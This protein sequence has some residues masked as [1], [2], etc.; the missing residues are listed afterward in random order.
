MGHEQGARNGANSISAGGSSAM[1]TD[2]ANH[3]S[4]DSGNAD[5]QLAALEQTLMGIRASGTTGLDGPIPLPGLSDDAENENGAN[6]SQLE[7]KQMEA[8]RSRAASARA[9]A[10]T[11]AFAANGIGPVSQRGGIQDPLPTPSPLLSFHDA[12]D[13][14]AMRQDMSWQIRNGKLVGV[15]KIGSSALG[16]LQSPDDDSADGISASGVNTGGGDPNA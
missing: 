5:A 9:A 14:R 8:A 1:G 15:R 6:G 12:A 7:Q 10:Q 16:T 11:A 13:R 3:H 2:S 4:L